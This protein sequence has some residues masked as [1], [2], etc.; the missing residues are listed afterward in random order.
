MKIELLGTG[1][2]FANARRDTACIVLPEWGIVFDAGSALYQLPQSCTASK[3]DLFLTHPHLDHIVGLPFLLMPVLS[4]T[5]EAV[6]VHATAG[7]LQA[8]ETHL[9][10]EAIFPVPVPFACDSISSSGRM[11]VRPGLTVHWQTL[12]SHP[13]QSM[14]YR[15]DD[16][17]SKCSFAY[18]TDTTVD[19]TYTEFIRGVDLLIH[20]CYFD[21]DRA[22]LAART[23]HSHASQV[24]QLAVDCDVERLVIVHLDPTLDVDDPIGLPGMQ[25]IFP[26]TEL[27]FD[28]MS[29]HVTGNL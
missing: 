17:H 8:V 5:Y 6:T 11:E 18:V 7:T 22:N 4:K 10:A 24:A 1:G 3:I 26:R 16:D 27:G 29:L 21:D 12:P 20:E 19:G 28:G 9:F 13:G 23:G 2:Y 25:A 14:A 15:V